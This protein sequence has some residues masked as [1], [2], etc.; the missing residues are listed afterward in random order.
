MESHDL[1]RRNPMESHDHINSDELYVLTPVTG[2]YPGRRIAAV[3]F[4]EPGYYEISGVEKNEW[5]DEQVKEFCLTD[6]RKRGIPDDVA[7]SAQQGSMFGWGNP[8]AALALEFLVEA[9]KAARN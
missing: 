5:T 3:R 4:L 7:V 6:N 9:R 8:C 2:G 1:K